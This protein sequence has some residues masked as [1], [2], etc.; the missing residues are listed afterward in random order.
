MQ[1]GRLRVDFDVDAQVEAHLGR[2]P[3]RRGEFEMRHGSGRY[4]GELRDDAAAA[5]SSAA[6]VEQVVEEVGVGAVLLG[7][8]VAVDGHGDVEVGMAELP[9]H[10]AR[11]DAGADELSGDVVATVVQGAATTRG[12][13]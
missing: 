11:V 9:G 10:G 7:E 3:D 4:P 1:S 8:G 5:R 6:A 2:R 12:G 13:R